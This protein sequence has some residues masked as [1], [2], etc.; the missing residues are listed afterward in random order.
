VFPA[1]IGFASG[2]VLLQLCTALPTRSALV[3]LA[4]ALAACAAVGLRARGTRNRALAVF[5]AAL[6]A[7]FGSTALRAHARM[8]DELARAD[9][10][11]DLQV[12]GV[13][14]SLPS[15]LP[16]L[17]RFLFE[18][19]REPGALPHVPQR[20]SLGWYRQDAPVLPAQRWEF[21]VRMRRPQATANPAGFDAEGWMFSEGVR[22]VGY[23]RDGPGDPPP[24]L[25]AAQAGN[26]DARVDRARAA[27]R[28]RLQ[29]LLQGSRH[30]AV[31]V[32]LVMGDQ[33]PIG[34]ADWSL[35]NRTGIS[36]LVSIS[37]LH[38][39]MIAA[40]VALA[41]GSLWR[42]SARLLR[43]ATLPVV[44]AA[45]G[46]LG[47]LAYCLLAGWGVPAQ[48]TLLMLAV[49]ALAH[50][51]RVRMPARCVLAAAAA[52]VCLWDPWAPLAAGF[53]LSFGAVACIFLASAGLEGAPRGKAAMAREAVR[54]QAAITVG[55]V[56]LTV[57][58][59]GQV[60]LVAPIAN[61][62]AIPLVSYVV[63]PLALAGAA[64]ASAVPPADPLARALLQAAERVFAA[65]AWFLGLLASQSWSSLALPLPSMAAILAASAGVAWLL[66]QPLW[67]L[68]AMG[69][70]WMLPMVLWPAPRPPPGELWVT[71]LDVGQGMAVVVEG[72]GKRILFDAGPRFSPEADAGSRV[73]VPW[74]HARGIARLDL[75]VISHPDL[76]HAGGAASV[77]ASTRVARLLTS[78]PARN[79]LLAGGPPP[80]RCEAG[81]RIALGALQLEVLSPPAALYDAPRASTNSRSCVVR[82]TLGTRSVL[83]TGDVPARE[84]RILV[85]GFEARPVD[86]LLAPHHGSH[87]SSSAELLDWASPRYASV[88]VG[89]RSRFGHPH[90]DVLARYS[91]RGVC[92]I[93]SDASGAAQWRLAATGETQ[94]ERWRV[95]HARYW[96]QRMPEA[97]S[98]GGGRCDAPR[99]APK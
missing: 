31:I 80:E 88:Q 54:L 37:G 92:V 26:F 12:R 81:Q 99:A 77:F 6:L 23:V 68:R 39:T 79:P 86:L 22:A 45:A 76:D 67:P 38:I 20:L 98:G 53:W 70:A 27:L 24:T 10:G 59:F 87:T 19:E 66:H 32:A 75:V 57:A 65:L 7:G 40:M 58:I 18:V 13:V 36:H 78:V 63:T 93:R 9:E 43:L 42:R 35:F 64:L 85:Q 1:L 94:I 91:A 74:L 46:I 3:A 51:A 14:A 89:Y 62:V 4:F 90:A 60:S 84:E 17:T 71:A 97:G 25:L 2:D 5:L 52:L 48:R 55:Q 8:A 56:P 61:A 72:G 41:V 47:G 29:D 95:E 28:T 69:A 82:A 34:E 83:L 49:V 73:V 50:C 21:T 15:V 44:R 16:G 30:G 33:G 11:V 96:T